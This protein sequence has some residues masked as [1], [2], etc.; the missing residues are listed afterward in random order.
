[1]FLLT[2][3]NLIYQR[4]KH[5]ATSRQ[6]R[7]DYKAYGSVGNEIIKWIKYF[8]QADIHDPKVYAKINEFFHYIKLI[9]PEFRQTEEKVQLLKNIAEEKKWISVK[10][11]DNSV[12]DETPTFDPETHD[13]E[14]KI[15]N[16]GT[17]EE[18]LDEI[19]YWTRFMLTGQK[20]DYKNLINFNLSGRCEEASRFIYQLACY[21]HLNA[22]I[23][24]IP[25]A[26]SHDDPLY[27]CDMEFHYFVLIEIDDKTYI[28]DCTYSQFFSWYRNE[29]ERLGNYSYM[30]CLPGIYMLKNE[31]REQV[32][33]TILNRGWIELTE[34]T[35]KH[36]FDGF[37]LSY[38]NGLFYENL[39][40]A[41][42]STP[43]D[44][45]DYHNFIFGEDSQLKREG[46]KYLGYQMDQLK[47][48]DFKF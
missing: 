14:F 3:D 37:A 38:R 30:G 8:D 11:D 48:S 12:I 31:S 16:P 23:I 27:D 42:Y 28:V 40:I 19:V 45:E 47:K 6:L 39:G 46:R 41:D 9:T 1:M 15:I 36:Y 33:R 2:N 18:I 29:I 44:I 17:P 20:H 32:A 5:P 10:F 4:I 22:Q 34:E 26:F 13:S 24:K 7:R 25:A 43:Y 35:A 21:Y